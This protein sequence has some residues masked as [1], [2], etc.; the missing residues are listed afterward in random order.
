MLSGDVHTG[1]SVPTRSAVGRTGRCPARLWTSKLLVQGVTNSVELD[2]LCCGRSFAWPT[3]A[4]GLTSFGQNVSA[5]RA[6][7]RATRP[8]LLEQSYNQLAENQVALALS[9]EVNE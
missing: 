4:V 7:V 5:L 3:S 9:D 2:P 1:H 8:C 6:A